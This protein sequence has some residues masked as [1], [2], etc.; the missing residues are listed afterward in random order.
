MAGPVLDNIRATGVI[1]APTPDIWPPQVIR[2]ENGDLD[3]FDIH[4]RHHTRSCYLG[5]VLRGWTMLLGLAACRVRFDELHLLSTRL[6][7]LNMAGALVLLYWEAR[8]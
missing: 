8:E 5:H 7:W 6:M 2:T 3:G 4:G 1:R